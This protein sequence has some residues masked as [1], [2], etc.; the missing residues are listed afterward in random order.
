M[1]NNR[2]SIPHKHYVSLSSTGACK[3]LHLLQLSDQLAFEF[4]FEA[5]RLFQEKSF[6]NFTPRYLYSEAR[7]NCIPPRTINHGFSYFVVI[8]MFDPKHTSELRLIKH[9][10]VQREVAQCSTQMVYEMSQY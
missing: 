4:V 7:G 1:R 9:Y 2:I 8:L 5:V 10:S 3:K 6:V